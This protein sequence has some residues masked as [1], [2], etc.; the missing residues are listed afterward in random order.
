MKTPQVI[1][2]LLDQPM[3]RGEFLRY[4]GV[5]GLFVMGGGMIAKSVME[6]EG[7]KNSHEGNKT[8]L[9][10]NSRSARGYGLNVYGGL[11]S[12]SV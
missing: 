1:K 9:T 10:P 4:M 12:R 6:L 2:N 7:S 8:A 11:K 3:D 5:A